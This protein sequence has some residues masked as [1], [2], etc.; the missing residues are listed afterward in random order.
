V[1]IT[2]PS[3]ETVDGSTGTLTAVRVQVDIRKTSFFLSKLRAQDSMVI[4]FLQGNG[5][6]KEDAL[7]NIVTI[8]QGTATLECG[9]GRCGEALW[10][11]FGRLRGGGHNTLIIE[12]AFN[13]KSNLG[14]TGQESAKT[15]A[16][17]AH[18]HE[19]VTTPAN[20]QT[21]AAGQRTYS[22]A[23]A[24]QEKPL[25]HP[26]KT[27]SQMVHLLTTYDHRAQRMVQTATIEEASDTTTDLLT[28]QE[29][30]EV[31]AQQRAKE[32]KISRLRQ[33]VPAPFAVE[34][35]L[36][37]E[38]KA[39]DKTSNARLKNP[40]EQNTESTGPDSFVDELLQLT[41]TC[42]FLDS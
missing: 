14:V 32:S 37:K 20:N 2:I 15:I 27:K 28:L 17:R 19:N 41:H 23:A 10:D 1:T 9:Q 33:N 24:K 11:A 13:R 36:A 7:Q 30:K 21:K 25:P 5:F 38:L 3:T 35:T 4:E 22:T 26:S 16:D 34:Q 6:L 8:A 29:P 42:I 31:I 12:S 40:E 18:L 39:G